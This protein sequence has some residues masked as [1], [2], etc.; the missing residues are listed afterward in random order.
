VGESR[1]KSR[2][3][4]VERHFEHPLEA[5]IAVVVGRVAKAAG[6]QGADTVLRGDT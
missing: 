4:V 2:L 3:N 5:T 1:R 6:A